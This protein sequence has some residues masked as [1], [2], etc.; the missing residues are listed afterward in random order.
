MEA[1]TE[2]REIIIEDMLERNCMHIDVKV[3]WCQQ[4]RGIRKLSM[5]GL[6]FKLGMKNH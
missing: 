6:F 3:G 5:F 1:S 2:E 4:L